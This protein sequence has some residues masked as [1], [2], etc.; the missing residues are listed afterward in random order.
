MTFVVDASMA[1]AWML[2]DEHSPATD[3]I[4]QKLLG[5]VAEVP[6]LFWHEA[7]NVLLMAER[8]GRIGSGEAIQFMDRLRRLPLEDAGAG[9]MTSCLGSRQRTV[10]V[11]TTRPISPLPSKLHCRW[12]PSIASWRRQLAA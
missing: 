7:R 10:S 8:R 4:L 1:A 9:S 11:S 3:A 12:P 5:T 6:S 2:P